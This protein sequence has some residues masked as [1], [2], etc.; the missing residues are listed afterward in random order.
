M[1]LEQRSAGPKAPGGQHHR[2]CC[3]AV[4]GAVGVGIQHARHAPTAALMALERHHLGW[5]AKTKGGG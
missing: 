5:R 4:L 3:Y 2:I 1:L